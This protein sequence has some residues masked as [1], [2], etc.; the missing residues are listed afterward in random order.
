MASKLTRK[1]YFHPALAVHQ[2]KY[3]TPQEIDAL[4]SRPDLDQEREIADWTAL[5]AELKSLVADGD[6]TSP[7]ALNLGRRRM[8]QV[9]K[10]TGGDKSMRGKMLNMAKDSLADPKTAPGLPFTAQ[11]VEFLGKIVAQ[12]A[13]APP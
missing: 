11:D 13:K 5:H 1:T 3:F 7:T 10:L 12:L 9:E 6:P 4:G 8:A 2:H